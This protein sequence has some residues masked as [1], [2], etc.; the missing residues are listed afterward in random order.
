MPGPSML[1]QMAKFHSF[2]FDWVIS[3]ACAC[4]YIHMFVYAC[5]Y[6]HIFFI[7]S[8][9]DGHLGSFHNLPTVNKAAWKLRG[10]HITSWISVFIFFGCI[11][12]SG[13]HSNSNSIFNSLRNL[14]TIFHSGCI[15]LHPHQQCTWVP[16]FS[17]PCQHLW[18]FWQQPL[19]Q[20]WGAISWFWYALLWWLAMLSIFSCLCWPSACFLWKNI[21]SSHC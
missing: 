4:V 20:V 12:S 13:I 1:L 21:Y 18:S 7:Y 3:I 9:T 17:C 2:F 11:S 8:S 6:M 10:E 14:H 16:F 5:V 15:N 19:W